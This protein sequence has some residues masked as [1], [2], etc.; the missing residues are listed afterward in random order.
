MHKLITAHKL[1]LP[2][3]SLPVIWIATFVA[4]MIALSRIGFGRAGISKGELALLIP[5]RLHSHPIHQT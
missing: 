3:G 4:T 2:I 5:R 1:T